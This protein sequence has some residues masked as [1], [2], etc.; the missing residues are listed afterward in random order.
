M[1]ERYIAPEDNSIF[2]RLLYCQCKSGDLDAAADVLK[3][4]IRLSIPTEAGHYGILIENFCKAGVYDR[5]VKLLDK[6]I[7][8]ENILRP[9][10]F[11]ELEASAYNPMIEYLCDHGQ[12]EKAE[13]FFR[14]LMKEGVQ[15]SVA[16]NNLTRG[17]AKE[18]NSDSAFEIL[19]IMG[20]RGVPREAD[21]YTLLIQS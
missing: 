15:D 9:Q 18:G 17:Y 12:A 13:V 7:E 21:S 1:D 6:L 19:K 4:M 20:R 16:F 3:A 8:K 2:E 5:A 11:M 10:S 14:Q